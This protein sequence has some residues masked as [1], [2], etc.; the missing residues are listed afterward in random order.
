MPSKPLFG[1]PVAVGIS[2]AVM[3]MR[4][5]VSAIAGLY[6]SKA[7]A[8]VRMQEALRMSM[9][10]LCPTIGRSAFGEIAEEKLQVSGQP[11]ALGASCR[12]PVIAALPAACDISRRRASPTGGALPARARLHQVQ[13]STNRQSAF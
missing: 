9:I 11:G 6:D 4:S 8:S 3:A 13:R 5:V 1:S 2:D 12:L 10:S 7:A